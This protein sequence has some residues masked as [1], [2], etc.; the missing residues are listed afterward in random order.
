MVNT[1]RPE[2]TLCDLEATPFAQQ[3]IFEWNAHVFEYKLRMS[4]R[5]VI[6]AQCGKWAN[7]AEARCLFGYQYLSLLLVSAGVFWIRFA[8]NNKYFTAFVKCACNKP[9][10]A[11][12]HPFIVFLR[13]AQFY[14][15]SIG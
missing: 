7:D 10:A 6:V 3:N 2:S 8:H 9:L 15:G 1:T 14:V 12:E 5:G 13:D 11:I 4:K